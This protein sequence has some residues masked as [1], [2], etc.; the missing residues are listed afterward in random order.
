M[1]SLAEQKWQLAVH[2]QLAAPGVGFV[3]VVVVKS[4]VVAV[5]VAVPV[6]AAVT[7]PLLNQQ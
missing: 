4:F 7:Q 2:K 1:W 3:V 6:A 5:I